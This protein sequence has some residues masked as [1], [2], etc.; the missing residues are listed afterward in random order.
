MKLKNFMQTVALFGLALVL[1]GC[2]NKKAG[3]QTD[4]SIKDIK[5]AKVLTVGTSAD[6]ESFEFPIVKDGKKEFVGYDMM[7][8]KKIADELGVKLKIVNIEFPSLISELNNNK[9]DLVLS[10][11]SKTK[12]REK[13]VD[14]SDSYYSVKNVLLVK[15]GDQDKYDTLKALAGKQIG[16]QQSTT[17]E[18]LVKKKMPDAN[19]VS[20]SLVTSLATELA[21][22]KLDGV[23]LENATAN[24]YAKKFSG[25]YAV[26]KV[27]LTDVKDV[28]AYSVAVKKGDKKLIKAVNK[29]IKQVKDSGQDG[30][31][32][33]EAQELQSKYVN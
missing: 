6:F 14:F 1:V 3:P 8:A 18:E 19:L 13:A 31:M 10:G 2:S 24:N 12:K 9:V 7:L 23:V 33:K 11:L 21:N 28:E 30:Q 26:A 25:K 29:V 32:L 20:E 15:K 5:K 17:Q 4:N 16:A 22:D 27:Q